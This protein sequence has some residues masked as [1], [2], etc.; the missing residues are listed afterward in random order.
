M[1]TVHRT[2]QANRDG[3]PLIM[4]QPSMTRPAAQLLP[5]DDAAGPARSHGN[6]Q[7]TS[8]SI[9]KGISLQAHLHP[10]ILSPANQDS[11]VPDDGPPAFLPLAT[12]AA[13]P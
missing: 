6:K 8:R 5:G 9:D 11:I 2:A 1:L 3:Q 12:R 10:V 7:L 4:N 13:E